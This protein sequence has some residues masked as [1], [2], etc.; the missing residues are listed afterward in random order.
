MYLYSHPRSARFTRAQTRASKSSTVFYELDAR[1]HVTQLSL[2]NESMYAPEIFSLWDRDMLKFDSG[3]GCKRGRKSILA[4]KGIGVG[5][6]YGA[7]RT[8]RVG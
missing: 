5:E 4:T 8:I 2:Q 6:V 3:E 7:K 1:N